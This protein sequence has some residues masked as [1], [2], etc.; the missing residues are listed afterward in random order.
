MVGAAGWLLAMVLAA[1]LSADNAGNRLAYLDEPCNPYYVG[2]STPRLITPQW[3]GEDGVDAVIV[4]AID[5]LRK[6]EVHEAFLRPV[7][8][9]LKRIDGRAAVSMMTNQLQGPSAIV[10]R[11]LAEGVSL[12]AHTFEHF[13]PC[14]QRNDLARA[15]SSFDQ[16][17]DRLTEAA[18]VAPVAFRMP[19]CDSMNSVSP[20]YFL[21]VFNKTTPGQ[22]FLSVD[23]SVFGLFTAADPALAPQVTHDAEGRERFRPYIPQDRIMTNYVENYPY[24]FV[25]GRLCWEVSPLMPSDWDAQHRNGKCSPATLRDWKA[26]VDAVVAKRGVFSICF[27]THGWIAAE[28]VVELVDYAHTRYGR[29]VKFLTFRELLERI[30]RNLLAGHPLRNAQGGDNGVRVL[31]VNSD[32]YMDVVIANDR[33]RVT[34]IWQPREQRWT[35]CAFPVAIVTDRAGKSCNTGVR[36]G[37]LDRTGRAAVVVRNDSVAGAWQFHGNRWVEIPKGLAG[38]DCDGPVFT[39]TEG[40][41]TGA[42]LRDVDGDG[43]CELLLGNRK[44]SAV[45]GRFRPASGWQRLPFTLPPGAAVVDSQGRDAGLRL[46]DLNEDG[47]LDVVFSDAQRYLVALFQSPQAGWS[48]VVRAGRRGEKSPGEEVPMIVRADGT[49]NGAWFQWGHMWV[50][51]EKTGKQLPGEVDSRSYAWLLGQRPKVSQQ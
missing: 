35:E 44:K 26:A 42:R 27:H 14:L 2:L 23:S 28:Q 51:N 38:L 37:V 48:Q 11:W 13:C 39:S 12:E 8:E 41:D 46:V 5:D 6:V 1:T 24:P 15:K 18:G 17:I 25:V 33:V 40:R 50:Q 4:L 10:Q 43:I 20:R 49:N 22:R 47:R 9:R 32:G 3:I 36:F 34:R 45:F 7:F 29:R 16:C 19:C 31:D 30:N 21:E